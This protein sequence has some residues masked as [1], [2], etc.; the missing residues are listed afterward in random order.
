MLRVPSCTQCGL[1]FD[2]DF[3]QVNHDIPASP[4][5]LKWGVSSILAKAISI[6]GT[7]SG[8]C[9]Y[10]SAGDSTLGWVMEAE[11]VTCEA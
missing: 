11:Q 10:P 9:E 2:H 7:V 1:C 3:E 8:L 5:Y 4:G 6:L